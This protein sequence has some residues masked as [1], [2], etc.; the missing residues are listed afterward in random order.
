MRATAA[1]I[2]VVG[3]AL[4]GCGD[5]PAP[6]ATPANAPAQ[7]AAPHGDPTAAQTGADGERVA[8]E[9]PGVYRYDPTGKR[10][11]FR[12]FHWDRIRMERDKL[13]ERGPLE[14]YDLSQLSVVAIVWSNDT[15]RALVEDPAG[16][17]YIV[18]EGS[19]MG[20]NDGKVLKIDD[21]L[22][23]VKETYY[24]FLAE[25]TTR[26]VELRIRTSRGG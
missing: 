9:A 24:N 14:Q 22:I 1:L 10:D 12:S 11:P 4:A 18:S 7:G 6:A 26:D 17:A 16:R 15:A 25:K 20:K 13:A 21:N 19:Q 5:D 8:Q 2:A 3:L 23:L